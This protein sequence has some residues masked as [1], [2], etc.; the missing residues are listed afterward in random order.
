VRILLDY[1]PALRARTGVGEFVH[2]LARALS[3]SGPATGD[4]LTLFTTSWRDRPDPGLGATL[5][6]AAVVDRKIPVR[7]LV[8]AWNR[9]EWPPIERLAGGTDVVHSQSPLLIP[10]AHAASIITIHDLH[11]LS[12]PEHAEAEIRRD[13][14][15]LVHDHA[16]R[17]DHV[18]VSSRFAA[19]DVKAR[20]GVPDDRVT[21]CAPGVPAWATG[22]ARSRDPQNTQEDPQNLQKTQKPQQ[23]QKAILFLGTLEPRKNIGGLLK[24]YGVLRS[25]HSDAPPLVLAG[26]IRE[27]LRPILAEAQAS[28]FAPHIQLPGYVSETDKQRL[29][30]EASM[31]VL[32]SFDEGFGLP[33]L[34]A[35]ACGVPVL[36]SNRGSLPEVTGDAATPVDPT[37]VEG[38][39]SE[40]AALLDPGR[41]ADRT[42]RGLARAATYSWAECA[43]H[44]RAAYAAALAV[45]Q[46]RS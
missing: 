10:S 12:H 1:R 6:G 36:V 19:A 20:L 38:M 4:S 32:P 37:D 27:S 42:A 5:G 23:A 33:V 14:P 8:W 7:A 45:R 34:E 3:L 17:A 28:P 39:A 26:G 13:F 25:R 46:Q 40:M 22:V 35:M 2:E 30:R 31:L 16:R 11:F 21:V 44:A 43:R 41:A 24:A 9:L 29:Y 15:A 18:I